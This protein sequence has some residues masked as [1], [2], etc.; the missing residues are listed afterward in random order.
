MATPGELVE[1]LIKL[2]TTVQLN[3]IQIQ[4]IAQVL[5]Q[6]ME[7]PQQNSK[8]RIGSHEYRTHE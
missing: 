7:P 4:G 1:Q 6:L 3:D 5:A 8:R 2:A